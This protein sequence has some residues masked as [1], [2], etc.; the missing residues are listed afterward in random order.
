MIVLTCG[1]SRVTATS[2]PHIH[3]RIRPSPCSATGSLRLQSSSLSRLRSPRPSPLVLGG[4]LPPCSSLFLGGPFRCW[5]QGCPFLCFWTLVLRVSTSASAVW[6]LGTLLVNQQIT[7]NQGAD[8]NNTIFYSFGALLGHL[9]QRMLFWVLNFE[10]VL[11]KVKPRFS[12]TKW[13]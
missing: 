10:D 8:I 13:K 12:E 9:T 3:L 1:R 5:K 11:I 7:F 6:T 4:F 2:S